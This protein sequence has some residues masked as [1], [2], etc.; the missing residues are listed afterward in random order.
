MA[1]P[2]VKTWYM[3]SVH[4][5]RA[6]G[7]AGSRERGA[8]GRVLGEVSAPVT[9]PGFVLYT[10]SFT[11]ED[12]RGGWTSLALPDL[13]IL[14]QGGGPGLKNLF[15]FPWGDPGLHLSGIYYDL[16]G[17]HF[18]QLGLRHTRLLP[19]QG[20]T[21]PPSISPSGPAFVFDF[22]ESLTPLWKNILLYMFN[23]LPMK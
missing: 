20:R 14:S 3:R 10:L 15:A 16:C 4:A 19:Q 8:G 23:L 7:K 22:P 12:E 11:P 2:V 9:W 13:G 5:L 6:A 18:P 17:Y 21:S 1:V